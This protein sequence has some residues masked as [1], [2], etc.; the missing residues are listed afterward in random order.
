MKPSH[1]PYHLTTFEVMDQDHDRLWA[2]LERLRD[3]V[4]AGQEKAVAMV[5]AS[6][7]TQFMAH[8]AMEER[9]M[10]ETGYSAAARHKQAHDLF[11]LDL[12]A[13]AAALQA[14]GLT[15][16]FRRW[17]T[18]RAQEWFRFHIG[19]NDVGLGQF[20]ALWERSGKPLPPTRTR[21]G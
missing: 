6:V 3:A 4:N 14:G 15:A 7:S 17:A 16:P 13:N 18:G 21:S 1:R 2:G 9:L 10:A 19:A 11:H 5:L 8:F 20:L 12:H